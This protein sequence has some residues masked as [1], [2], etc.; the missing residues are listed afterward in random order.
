[1]PETILF[2][3]P[4]SQPTQ[5]PTIEKLVLIP[6]LAVTNSGLRVMSQSLLDRAIAHMRQA[7]W[8]EASDL[9]EAELQADPDDARTLRL[10]GTTRFMTDR[11]REAVEFMQRSLAVDPNSASTHQN[12]GTVYLALGQTGEALEC[13]QNAV[14]LDPDSADAHYNLGVAYQRT[15]KLEAAQKQ[16]EEALTIDSGFGDAQV[17]LAAIYLS[18]GQ[19]RACI[20]VSTELLEQ[21]PENYRLRLNRSRAFRQIGHLTEANHDLDEA[22]RIAPDDPAV[23]VERGA[24]LTMSGH[25]NAAVTLLRE[26]LQSAPDSGR[27]DLELAYALSE[28][29]RFDEVLEV[30]TE[31]TTRDPASAERHSC[32]GETLQ[33]LGRADEARAAHQRAIELDDAS[34]SAR[35]SYGR[36]LLAQDLRV[37]A[38]AELERAIESSPMIVFP[39]VLRV[40]IKTVESKYEEALEICERYL[41]ANPSE[42]NML[43]V[44]ALLLN[45]LGD[46]AAARELVDFG[47]FIKQTNVEPPA[48]YADLDSFNRALTSH[49]RAHPTLVHSPQSHATRGGMHTGQLLVEPKGP[50]AAFE[51]ILWSAAHS[52][53]D[54][55]GV[56]ADHPFL[57]APPQLNTLACWSVVLPSQG[58]QVPHIHPAAWLSGV[59]YAELPSSMTKDDSTQGWI[60]FGTPPENLLL[61]KKAPVNL[62]RPKE[63]LLILFPSYFYHRTIPFEGDEERVSIAFD[64]VPEFARL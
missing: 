38:D 3:Q 25:L 44:K 16:Y 28:L 5:A 23:S 40:Q 6:Y 11:S 4:P 31:S 33:R 8:L 26:V 57:K 47:R 45:E 19:N 60:E 53:M 22:S 1:M 13:F 59:Y 14:Q 36:T 41:S 18:R 9:L 20:E 15:N 58:L 48:G 7:Q 42:R 43:A 50:F 29:G 30:L 37:E 49:V 10:L 24:L 12:L 54:S 63:G 2:A 35:L 46:E 21:N 17:N 27:A 34:A 52:Y 56:G 55:I 61:T 51:E 39:H 64:F 32:L 62:I